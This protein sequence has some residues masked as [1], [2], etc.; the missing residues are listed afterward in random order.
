MMKMTTHQAG[1]QSIR[2]DKK[3]GGI[4]HQSTQALIANDVKFES[5]N[6]GVHLIIQ[7][8]PK[9]DFYPSTGLW[10]VRGNTK[11]RRGVRKLIQYIK[12]KA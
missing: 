5:K 12:E 1:T 3:S 4:L 10:T 2:R 6:N 8:E 7:C 11:K 9:I